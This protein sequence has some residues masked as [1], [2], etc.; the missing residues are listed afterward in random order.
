M[1]SNKTIILTAALL[2]LTFLAAGCISSDSSS[3]T[4]YPQANVPEEVIDTQSV[5][6]APV[7]NV[8]VVAKPVVEVPVEPNW[9]DSKAGWSDAQVGTYST[10]FD[11]DVEAVKNI[12][13]DSQSY[14]LFDTKTEAHILSHQELGASDLNLERELQPEQYKELV[15]EYG[16]PVHITMEMIDDDPTRAGMD[17]VAVKYVGDKGERTIF[18]EY[19]DRR[20]SPIAYMSF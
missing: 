5:E 18:H 3:Q 12:I 1:Q 6:V 8:Q 10:L 15:A 9:W 20:D 13:S 19:V 7:D 17:H 16:R 11:T 4:T 14:D 2:I